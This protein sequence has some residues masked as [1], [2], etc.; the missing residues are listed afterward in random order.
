[1]F[2]LEQYATSKEDHLKLFNSLSTDLIENP[3][4]FVGYSLSDS[5][6]QEVWSTIKQ[7]CKV[8]KAPNRYYFVGPFLKQPFIDFLTS[9]GFTVFNTTCD[10]F[11]ELLT[12]QTKGERRT[13]NQYFIDHIKPINLFKKE[14]LTPK[15]KYKISNN[16][17]FPEI[18]VG[19]PHS[20][21]NSF[22]NGNECTWGDIKYSL[23][24][25]RDLGVNLLEA[26]ENWIQN[27][28]YD[29]WLITGRAGDGK[30]T[31]LKRFAYEAALRLG[32][33]VVFAKPKSDLD[34]EDI[35]SLLKNLQTPIV[36][37]IDNT[38]D[39]VAKVNNLL[40]FIKKDKHKILIIGASR[41]SDWSISRKDFFIKPNDFR[42]NK[43]SDEEINNIL[44]VL[45]INSSLGELSN[46]SQLERFNFFKNESERELL[47]ALKEATS[48]R[49]FEEIIAH[50]FAEIKSEEAKRAYLLICL[51]HQFRYRV[52]QSLLLRVL[53]FS[54]DGIYQK[55]F[56]FT[57]EII[58]IDD[59]SDN[60]D[61]LLRARHSVIAKTVVD[62]FLKDDVAKFDFLKE[63][64]EKHIPSN[65]LESSLIR[66]IYHHT[67]I[68]ALFSDVNT[69]VRCY[70][71][72]EKEVPGNHFILQQKAIFLSDYKKDYFAS[73]S[74]IS[75]AIGLNDSYTLQN[76]EGT[77][78]LKEALDEE[79][80]DKSKYLLEK[81]KK[82]LIAIT[83]KNFKN[84]SYNYHSLVNHMISW[85]Q[86]FDSNDS[87]IL[88]EIQQIIDEASK[89]HPNDHM[90]LTEYGKL[91]KLL[92]KTSSAIDYFTK[93]ITIN[94]RNF[95][96]R[97]LLARALYSKGDIQ[98]AFNICE[99]GLAISNENYQLNRTRFQLA[100]K[101]IFNTQKLKEDYS[102]ILRNSH[103]DYLMLMFAAFLY[104]IGDKDCEKMFSKLKKSPNISFEERF[105]PHYEL[106]NLLNI[107]SLREFG[108][109][110]NVSP[111]GY[112][113]RTTR[114]NTYVFAF[115]P[116]RRNSILYKKGDSFEY[117]YTF[118]FAGPYVIED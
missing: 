117:Q 55:I 33:S 41:I 45:K 40:N 80:Y 38:T 115:L 87:L 7:Y 63:L 23:D 96:A 10:E 109:I 56:K 27:P 84:N 71:L 48:Q 1:M 43:L 26:L 73:K 81:G 3:V 95:A 51:I 108:I 25:R 58:Y 24:A 14:T 68:R 44:E 102:S 8:T 98:E 83:R 54:I 16:Y 47:V 86:K 100:H 74:A 30:S 113:I 18:E 53:E 97:N 5:N 79:D 107:K 94:D 12:V 99:K 70:D 13:L 77:I 67:T 31:I 110:E 72:L 61:F 106:Q 32:E 116:R 37:F 78:Y 57:E 114:F 66:K 92:N 93:A 88:Q 59:A 103:D 11:F 19:Y 6:F 75:R 118:T 9:E 49:K 105:L 15:F 111:T 82:I 29:L 90:I 34:P 89:K 28:N 39:R 91:D 52:P 101:L 69:G 112:R 35:I 2:S 20:K 4:V 36:L 22:Y 104:S 42:L 76:T 60:M 50:E 85:Y 65:S 21:T 62:Y 46:F 17:D 64:L